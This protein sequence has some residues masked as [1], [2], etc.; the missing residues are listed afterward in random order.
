VWVPLLLLALLL[1]LAEPGE[2]A[3]VVIGMQFLLPLV[4]VQVVRAGV[5]RAPHGS[6][7]FGVLAP[8]VAEGTPARF[9]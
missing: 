7:V 9:R 3:P 4:P 1:L 5:Q 6:A 2:A 8:P